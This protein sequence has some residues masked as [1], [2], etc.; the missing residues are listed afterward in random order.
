MSEAAVKIARILEG[1]YIP[2]RII[3]EVVGIV[4][5]EVEVMRPSILARI[6]WWRMCQEIS[7]VAP[8][9]I[10]EDKLANPSHRA[11]VYEPTAGRL[12]LLRNTLGLPHLEMAEI[13]ENLKKC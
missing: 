9:A 13:R 12:Y 5:Y 6:A 10:L 2:S 11:T 1:A 7:S 3:D 8:L 4:D